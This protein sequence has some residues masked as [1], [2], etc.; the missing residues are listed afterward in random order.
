M[1]VVATDPERLGATG[2]VRVSYVPRGIQASTSALEFDRARVQEALAHMRRA[3]MDLM[4]V[5]EQVDFRFDQQVWTAHSLYIARLLQRRNWLQRTA[6]RDAEGIVR[7]VQQRA[8]TAQA[9]A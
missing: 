3:G 8:Q 4:P 7:S 5:S 9:V 1:E 6:I 2:V